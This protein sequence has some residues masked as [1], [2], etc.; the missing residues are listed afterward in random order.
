MAYPDLETGAARRRRVYTRRQNRTWPDPGQESAESSLRIFVAGASGVLGARFVPL[1]VS[2][3]HRVTGMTRTPH[4]LD[5]LRAMGAKPV[6]CDVYDDDKL[7]K[8]LRE[9]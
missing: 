7:R 6:L 4:R 8:A 5:A 1:L 3:G 9:S 2:R